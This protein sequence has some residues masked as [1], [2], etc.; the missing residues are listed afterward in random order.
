MTLLVSALCFFL[1]LS[2]LR[3]FFF[4]PITHNAYL[5]MSDE[6]RGYYEAQDQ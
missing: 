1:T 6:E 4:V 3:L 2:N 5:A